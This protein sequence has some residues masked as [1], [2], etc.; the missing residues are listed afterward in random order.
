MPQPE[1]GVSL[2]TYFKRCDDSSGHVRELDSHENKGETPEHIQVLDGGRCLE[3]PEPH[4]IDIRY[5]G[6]AAPDC[7]FVCCVHS[8]SQVAVSIAHHKLMPVGEDTKDSTE[9]LMRVHEPRVDMPVEF[10][11]FL[12]RGSPSMTR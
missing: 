11:V 8:I 7:P 9:L 12:R 6:E 3:P 1:S 5:Q 10:V 2:D 4:T